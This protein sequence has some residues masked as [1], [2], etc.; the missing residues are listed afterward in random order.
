MD[1]ASLAEEESREFVAVA[2][3]RDAAREAARVAAELREEAQEAADASPEPW[4]APPSEEVLEYANPFGEAEE[5]D[6]PLL[7]KASLQKTVLPWAPKDDQVEEKLKR[8][9]MKPPESSPGGKVKKQQGFYS[10]ENVRKRLE[11]MEH[12][13][14]LCLLQKLWLSA[15]TDA[16][17]AIIDHDEYLV[18]HRKSELPT[19]RPS[20]TAFAARLDMRPLVTYP[21]RAASRGMHTAP[22]TFLS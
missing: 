9:G 6:V 5:E 1:V 4:V 10:E 17:D 12:P 13:D 14:V 8:M 19:H 20:P 16:S 18:M 22:F 11:L 7:E 15:N 21:M 3:S 2:A